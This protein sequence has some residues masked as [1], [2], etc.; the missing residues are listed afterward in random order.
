M[1]RWYSSKVLTLLL[2]SLTILEI[3]DVKKTPT[4]EHLSRKG[5]FYPAPG[6]DFSVSLATTSAL[7]GLGRA[8]TLWL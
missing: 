8:V 3:L 4:E 5:F 7:K 2:L 6:T 1:A